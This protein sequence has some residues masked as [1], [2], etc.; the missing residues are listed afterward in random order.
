MIAHLRGKLVDKQPNLVTIDVGGVGYAVTI[1]VSTYSQLGQ[2]G[3]EAALHIHTHVREDALALFGFA[4]R[5]EKAIF[6]KLITVSGIG[7]RLAVT[8]LSGLPLDELSKAIRS[9]DV[10]RLTRIPGVGKKT[11]ERMVLELREKLGLVIASD[12][13]GAPAGADDATQQ[14]VI[15]ALLNLGCTRDAAQKAVG[16]A[17]REKPDGDALDFE[18]L[19]RRSLDLISR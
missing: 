15:S 11:G 1:P 8:V 18:S 14:E 4:T 6:Q 16:K 13:A 7:A 3:G 19:F 12:E 9:G 17:L 10:T 2:T 5:G